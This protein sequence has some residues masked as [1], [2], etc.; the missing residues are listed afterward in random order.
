M[1]CF[2]E[3]LCV[4]MSKSHTFVLSTYI[5]LS[6]ILILF[7]CQVFIVSFYAS[8]ELLAWSNSDCCS[9]LK[10]QYPFLSSWS[11]DPFSCVTVETFGFCMQLKLSVES[12]YP[13]SPA[14]AA[15][16]WG[17]WVWH[18]VCVVSFQ[19]YVT[20]NEDDEKFVDDVKYMY[21]GRSRIADEVNF[22]Y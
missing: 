3:M 21:L 15:Y 7:Y 16:F 20:W 5:L 2:F 19:W 22:F 10:S 1:N 11:A 14:N 8:K 18:P 17:C 9:Y 4:G 12:G 6:C 13:R